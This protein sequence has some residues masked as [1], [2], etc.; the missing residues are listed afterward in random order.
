MANQDIQNKLF[1]RAMSLALLTV[2]FNVLEGL[3]SIYFGLKDETLTLFGFGLD[4][5]VET[6]SASGVMLMVL[7]IKK[8]PA[9]DKGQFEILALKITGW[10]FYALVLLLSTSALYNLIE[11]KQPVSTTAGVI[12]ASFSIL[13]MWALIHY[14]MSIGKKLNSAPVIADAKCNQVCLYMSLILL[15]ASGFWWLWQ[16]PY[17]DIAGTAGL[18]YFSVKEGREAFDKAKG[19]ECDHCEHDC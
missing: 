10:S 11:G 6:I 16:I 3:V 19:I 17:I 2:V 8:N 4:S 13:T 9:S 5:F 15:T 14:K 1:D 18:V 12:I 7:R